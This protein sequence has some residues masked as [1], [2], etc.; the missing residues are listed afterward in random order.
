[1]LSRVEK[2]AKDKQLAKEWLSQKV[3]PQAGYMLIML[4]LF[5]LYRSEGGSLSQ[6]MFYQA[7]REAIPELFPNQN[8]AVVKTVEGLALR[9]VSPKW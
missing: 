1:M 7:I 8:V 2:V 5:Y 3:W 4:K 6:I 9:N